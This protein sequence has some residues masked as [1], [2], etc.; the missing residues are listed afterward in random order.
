LGREIVRAQ[1]LLAEQT[2]YE[3]RATAML[4]Q[5]GA[6][7]SQMNPREL[8]ERV[9]RA[10]AAVAQQAWERLRPLADLSD[11]EPPRL[12][13]LPPELVDRFVG[14]SHTH[15]LRVYARGDIW[16]MEQLQHFVRDVE[17]VDPQV[18]GHPVQ[19]YYASRHMQWGYIWAGIYALAAVFVFLWLDFRSIGHTL[20]AMVPLLVG[21]VQLCGLIG[22][23]GIPFNAANMIALP[24]ILGIGVDD[25]VH[26]VHELRRAR[27]P[28][29][30]RNATSIAVL[31]ISTTTTA[32]FGALILARHQGLQSLGQVLTLGVT[33]CLFSSVVFF[34]ALLA[35]LTRNRIE[36]EAPPNRIPEI[37]PVMD[38][39]CE[40][41]IEPAWSALAEEETELIAE[42]EPV[43]DEVVPPAIEVRSPDVEELELDAEPSLVP[44]RRIEPPAEQ[45]APAPHIAAGDPAK[46]RGAALA[47]L[48]ERRESE[49]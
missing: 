13:E 28:F 38:V 39:P 47:H 32:S 17:S 46:S 3:T 31:L 4:G 18:T 48:A 30:M 41:A 27:G 14:Q 33:T 6:V 10:Q 40:N 42:P 15:L 25:G 5:L 34:P 21:F 16:D 20:L 37:S 7:A 45:P 1:Q 11:P 43:A 35:W 8:E 24:L 26:L 29:R 44:R 12:A 23:L 19:T 9:S 2:P 49:R 22:W 36:A